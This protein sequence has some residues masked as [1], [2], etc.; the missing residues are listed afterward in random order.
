MKRASKF[1]AKEWRATKVNRKQHSLFYTGS[2]TN[3]VIGKWM[4]ACLNKN[5]DFIASAVCGD[6]SIT[7]IKH[8]GVTYFIEND[9][10]RYDTTIGL[11]AIDFELSF[12]DKLNYFDE[13]AKF[14]LKQQRMTKG[15]T[16]VGVYYSFPGERK[17]GDPNTSTGNSMITGVTT[18]TAI[19]SCIDY[20]PDEE[21]FC[22]RLKEQFL[23]F[24]F[25]AKPKISQDI[26][27]VEFCSKLFWPTEDGIILGP[28]PGRCLPKIG[29]GLKPLT[30]IQIR[31]V[32]KGWAMD[33]WFVPGIATYLMRADP[34]CCNSDV[35]VIYENAYST[36]STKFHDPNEETASFFY[37]RYGIT[38]GEFISAL[39][40]AFDERENY[41]QCPAMEH[42]F[43]VDI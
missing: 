4:E 7:V 11:E 10:S 40:K 32:F 35:K 12:Y 28:K 26:S 20:L 14:V 38:T 23:R 30:N 27:Q 17:S 13:D 37:D 36:H 25:N 3:E 6:D 34:T 16:R 24:G 5:D 41:L 18:M 33:G 29:C 19:R 31:G 15:Y 42:L 21:E 22:F 8:K 1:L 2:S 9:F 43:K 39:E